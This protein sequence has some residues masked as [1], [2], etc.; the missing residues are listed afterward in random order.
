MARQ[1]S[2]PVT[3][4]ATSLVERVGKRLRARRKALGLTLAE[5]AAAADVSISYLSAIEKGIHQPSLQVLARIVHALSLTIADVL[6]A[7]GQNRLLQGRI[8][9]EPGERTLSHPGLHLTIRALVASE[10]ETGESPVPTAQHDIFVYVRDG[11]L[12]VSVAGE[13]YELRVGDSL[14]ARCPESVSWE[15][16]GPGR[17][18]AIW[19]SAAAPADANG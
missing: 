2:D 12:R 15:A 19:S 18:V 9:D 17:T 8:D 5:V 13:D 16:L 10:G 4:E 6:R 7:E 1:S 3:A 11:A 14:D